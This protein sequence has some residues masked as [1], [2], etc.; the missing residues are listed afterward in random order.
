MGGYGTYVVG[1][2]LGLVA[3]FALS[4]GLAITGMPQLLLFG[5]LP[6]FGG[7]IA[8]RLAARRR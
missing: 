5:V 7:A 2:A 6:A 3:A 4:A 8:E 1:V